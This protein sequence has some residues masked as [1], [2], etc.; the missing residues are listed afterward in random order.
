[1]LTL[2]QK[3]KGEE[4][5]DLL[6]RHPVIVLQGSAGVGKTFLLGTIINE[7]CEISSPRNIVCSAPTHKALAVLRGKIDSPVKFST[8]HAEL[9]YKMKRD[10][11][12]GIKTFVST[13]E[14]EILKGVDYWV[15]DESSMIDSEML[16]CAIRHATRRQTKIIFVG[17]AKQLN[18]VGEADSP[19]FMRNFPTVE[20]TEI[21]RQGEGNP[22]IELSRNIPE[23]YKGVANV[24]VVD[25]EATEGFLYTNNWDK[26]IEKLA[27]SNGTDKA[28]FIAWTNAKVDRINALTRQK[29]YG[30]NPAYLEIGETLLLNAAYKDYTNNEEIKI[31][32]LRKYRKEVTVKLTSGKNPETKNISLEVYQVNDDIEVICPNSLTIFKRYL[33]ITQQNCN[34]KL[35]SWRDREPLENMFAD[36]KYN[37]AVTVHKSQGSSYES[38]ILDVGDIYRNSTLQERNRLYYTGITRASNLLVLCNINL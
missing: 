33:A 20:L 8:A 21:I 22:I 29:I 10:Y 9:K 7:L 6:G 16:D 37:H 11:D 30:D 27:E 32:T 31:D 17:D 36:F 34:K 28:K 14:P 19:V 1:M 24:K 4:L 35:L 23:M 2:H 26:I 38:V 25:G 5:L 12:T 3:E 15:I 18:P 13:E